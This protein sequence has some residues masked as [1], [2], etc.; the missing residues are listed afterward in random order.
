M[1]KKLEQHVENAVVYSVY[2]Q[3]LK[4]KKTHGTRFVGTLYD[5]KAEIWETY[6]FT[7]LR[8]YDTE[9]AVIRHSDMHC[10]DFL[11]LVYGYTA[12]SA[13]HVAK[14]CIHENVPRCDKHTYKWV[15]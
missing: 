14:F 15:D 12:T 9:V 6:G 3:Y 8:S 13:S 4:A 2:T 1:S 11:R 5:C 10:Y 7:I